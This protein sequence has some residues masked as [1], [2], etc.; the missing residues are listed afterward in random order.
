MSMSI[1]SSLFSTWALVDFLLSLS[2]RESNTASLP[3][4]LVGDDLI[5]IW[6]PTFSIN[7]LIRSSP[8]C[9]FILPSF[10]LIQLVEIS[11]LGEPIILISI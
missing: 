10:K 4:L 3:S 7:Y 5:S 2:I 1:P 8:S 9:T 11:N 6:P